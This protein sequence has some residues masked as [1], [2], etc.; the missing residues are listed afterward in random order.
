MHNVLKNSQCKHRLPK[1]DEENERPVPRGSYTCQHNDV[2]TANSDPVPPGLSCQHLTSGF[3]S[4][5]SE[6]VSLMGVLQLLLI[7]FALLIG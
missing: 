7:L 2:P 6:L 5:K 1:D 3:E 4:A